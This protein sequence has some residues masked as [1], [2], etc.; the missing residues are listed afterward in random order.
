MG[1]RIFKRVKNYT[2]INYTDIYCTTWSKYSKAHPHIR[3]L[4]NRFINSILDILSQNQEY[5]FDN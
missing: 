2:Q 1:D 5:N 3:L 4:I